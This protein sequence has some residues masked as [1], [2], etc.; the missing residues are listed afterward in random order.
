[1]RKRNLSAR[2]LAGVTGLSKRTIGDFLN[3]ARSTRV[4]T[5]KVLCHY[6]D[7]DYDSLS[8]NSTSREGDDHG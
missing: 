2:K 8:L 3:D 5:I 1:M 6:L 7:L 4:A